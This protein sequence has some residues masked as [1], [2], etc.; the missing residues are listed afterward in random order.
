MTVTMEDRESVND[1]ENQHWNDEEAIR[2]L[3]IPELRKAEK[4]L[5]ELQ[6]NSTNFDKF[7]NKLETRHTHLK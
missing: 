5:V 6:T 1:T 7:L 3:A 4:R 2:E